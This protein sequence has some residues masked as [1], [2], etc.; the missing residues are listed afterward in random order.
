MVSMCFQLMQD[1]IV[2]KV[3]WLLQKCKPKGKSSKTSA[4]KTEG[5]E[6]TLVAA[7]PTVISNSEKV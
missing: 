6:S 4:N 1:E 3:N 7:H 2:A 5:E